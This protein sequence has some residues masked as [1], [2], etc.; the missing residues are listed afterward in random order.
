MT[1]ASV[2]AELAHEIKFKPNLTSPSASYSPVQLKGFGFRSGRTFESIQVKTEAGESTVF[3]KRTVKGKIDMVVYRIEGVEPVMLLRNNQT[4][5]LVQLTAPQKKTVTGADGKTYKRTTNE[6]IG[7]IRAIKVI[8][9]SSEVKFKEEKI[10]DDIALFNTQ[11]NTNY[12]ALKYNEPSK[13]SY[14]VLTGIP[15]IPFQEDM[16]SYRVSIYRNRQFLE[17]SRN[18]S[19]LVAVIYQN[20]SFTNRKTEHFLNL[21]PLGATFRSNPNWI[22]PY[23][24][25]GAGL[26]IYYSKGQI[27]PFPNLLFGAGVDIK[28]GPVSLNTEIVPSVIGGI[29]GNVGLSFPR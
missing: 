6:F 18:V 26:G 27:L 29:I 5:Q 24:Y 13:Y 11:F 8:E 21:I 14:T 7:Q 15:V 1:C 25:V 2:D 17:K 22:R 4:H 28:M 9:S 3:G 16:S 23:F 19:S 20:L 12:S 10:K